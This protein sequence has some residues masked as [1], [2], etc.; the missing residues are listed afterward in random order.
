MSRN[1]DFYNYSYY[2]A[3][4]YFKLPKTLTLPLGYSRDL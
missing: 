1:K 3:V 4:S 2:V